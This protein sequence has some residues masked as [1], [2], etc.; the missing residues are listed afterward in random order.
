MNV[1]QV[2][3]GRRLGSR[4]PLF[5]VEISNFRYMGGDGDQT[6]CWWSKIKMRKGTVEIGILRRIISEAMVPWA[7]RTGVQLPWSG[8]LAEDVKTPYPL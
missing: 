2:S 3:Y 5:V 7:F 8:G 6:Y 4:Q 1:L